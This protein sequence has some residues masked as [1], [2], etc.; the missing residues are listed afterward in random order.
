T[1]SEYAFYPDEDF[2]SGKRSHDAKR[3]HMRHVPFP[4]KTGKKEFLFL[5]D[6]GDEWHF[7]VKLL[8]ESSTLEPKARYPRVVASEGEN[9]PQYP[10]IPE[11]EEEIVVIE[12]SQRDLAIVGL[13]EFALGGDALNGEDRPRK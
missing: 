3:T 5:F 13:G 9:P 7:G 4:G 2:F 1:A 11:D 8:R 6:F 10:D 12:I